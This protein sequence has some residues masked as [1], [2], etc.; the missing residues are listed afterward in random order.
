M[1]IREGRDLG[2]ERLTCLQRNQVALIAS[3]SWK[4]F[5]GK[6]SHRLLW[7][8]LSLFLFKPFSVHH[9]PNPWLQPNSNDLRSEVTYKNKHLK[10]YQQNKEPTDVNREPAGCAGL[11]QV[12]QTH[13]EPQSPSPPSKS[14]THDWVFPVHQAFGEVRYVIYH[15]NP[16]SSRGGFYSY[17]RFRNENVTLGRWVGLLAWGPITRRESRQ[18]FSS[19]I[20]APEA[21][22]I[23][24]TPTET[25][26]FGWGTK[27]WRKIKFNCN[28]NHKVE[29]D[30]LLNDWQKTMEREVL[31]KKIIPVTFV[32]EPEEAPYGKRAPSKNWWELDRRPFQKTEQTTKI[33]VTRYHWGRNTKK[34]TINK[35]QSVSFIPA[36]NLTSLLASFTYFLVLKLRKKEGKN[37]KRTFSTFISLL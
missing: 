36:S 26:Y 10:R 12:P 24:T 8:G 18:N 16:S 28:N 11:R 29:D 25:L 5:E 13:T 30:K 34:V 31:R 7:R 23:T 35:K 4:E 14:A 33:L 2:A 20:W 1:G 17:P 21:E 19:G 9:P 22:V 15:P 27:A 3:F 32:K 37:F 6:V